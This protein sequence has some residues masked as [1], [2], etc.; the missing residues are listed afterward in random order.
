MGDI[1]QAREAIV[2]NDLAT[3]RRELETD[4]SASAPSQV[5]YLWVLAAESGEQAL[6][7]V[8]Q[9]KIDLQRMQRQAGTSDEA[10]PFLELIKSLSDELEDAYMDAHDK[11]WTIKQFE[12]NAQEILKKYRANLVNVHLPRETDTYEMLWDC[13]FCGTQGNLGLSHRFCPNCGAPQNPDSRYFPADDAKVAVHDHEFVGTDVTCPA[14]SQL[15]S[16]AAEFCGQCGSPLTEGARAKTLGDRTKQ[17]GEMLASSGARDVVKEAFEAEQRRVGNLPDEK[18][19]NDGGMGRVLI[20]VAA[21]AI[22]LIGG[23]IFAFTRT[24]ETQVVVT[25]HEWERSIVIERYE[26][27]TERDWRDSPPVGD[28]VS[29][30]VGSCSREQRSTN[31]VPDGEECSVR[32]VDQ[33]D[34][35]FRE[36]EECRTI[37]REEPVY[38]DMCTWTGFRWE[39]DRTETTAGDL[40]TTP[41]WASITLNCEGQ[42]RDG[43]EREDERNDVY[44]VLFADTE[45]DNTYDCSFPQ[46]DWEAMRVDSVWDAEVRLLGGL[47]CDSISRQ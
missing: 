46:S 38:D 18:P 2:N 28:N 13:Q 14:C 30:R 43:C 31:R 8:K 1:Q 17:K 19:K 40:S 37:Y 42:R 24:S 39:R 6:E 26:R 34:G 16:A 10:D 35:T 21:V 11:Q 44:R 9:A 22:L 36:V 5:R 27:F 12:P 32:Q 4:V 33:G 47:V 25:D 7:R 20:G 15:N 23:L 41:Y 29:I 45:N 3:A